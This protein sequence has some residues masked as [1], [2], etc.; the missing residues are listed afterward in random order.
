M[1]HAQ[2]FGLLYGH[3]EGLGFLYRLQSGDFVAVLC[4][5]ISGRE[6]TAIFLCDKSGSEID[7]SKALAVIRVVDVEKALN[8]I[9]HTKYA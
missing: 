1:Y 5:N 8:L 9:G 3:S 2:S 7:F 6:E 4:Q